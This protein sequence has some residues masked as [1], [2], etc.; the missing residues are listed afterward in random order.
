MTAN[1]WQLLI[2]SALAA[3]GRA[4]APYSNFTVGAALMADDGE[5]FLG[6]NV[7]NASYGMTICA[8]RA[9]VCSAVVAGQQKFRALAIATAGGHAPCGACRQVLA[10]FNEDLAILIINADLPT[11]VLEV[12]L[13]ALLPGK[14]TLPE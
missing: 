6:C 12:S 14:F 3:R 7:E 2:D 1:D 8:E 11:K 9:A 13:K 4:Y 10:E 5:I